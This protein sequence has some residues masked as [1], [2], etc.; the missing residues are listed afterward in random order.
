VEDTVRAVLGWRREDY[1]EDD[2]DEESVERS[3]AHGRH[4]HRVIVPPQKVESLRKAFARPDRT[5]LIRESGDGDKKR[6]SLGD[7]VANVPL[8]AIKDMLRQRD[9]FSGRIVAFELGLPA[10]RCQ[11][12]FDGLVQ[13]GF[14]EPDGE[15]F[16]FYRSSTKGRSLSQAK[17]ARRLARDKAAAL[18]AQLIARAEAINANPD[19]AHVVAE[20]RLYGS[21]LNE[22]AGEV[23]DVDI[24]FALNDRPRIGSRVAASKARWAASGREGGSFFQELVY[25]ETEVLA[26]LK[27]RSSYL[28]LQPLSKIEKL[29]CPTKVMFTAGAV[30]PA[31]VTYAD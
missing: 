3:R 6:L 26:L 12:I 9:S 10:E 15:G 25:G 21:L 11:A 2:W 22:T 4:A 18:L 19:L 29:G 24:A 30:A 31:R 1:A 8:W 27:G 20:L 28:S 7:A 5:V 14:L 16:D 23:G 17:F 13:Q